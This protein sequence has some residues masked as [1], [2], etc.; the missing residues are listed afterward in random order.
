MNE[1]E[2]TVRQATPADAEE[3]AALRWEWG[4]DA[5]PEA[6]DPEWKRYSE[7]L[8]RWMIEHEQTHFAFVAEE[9]V[10]TVGMA[11]LAFM[12]RV[13][14]PDRFTRVGADLQS[15][16]VKPP[17]RGQGI[18]I[19][20]VNAVVEAGSVRARHMTVRTGRSATSFYP[21]LGFA[22][23]ATSLERSLGQ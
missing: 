8:A 11:W 23:N 5:P 17:W 21:Q 13:P 20:L 4:H 16:Y 9:G 14:A 10:Q 6:G 18:G 1:S 22:V 3:L 7:H 2:V 12:P 15:V 19:R